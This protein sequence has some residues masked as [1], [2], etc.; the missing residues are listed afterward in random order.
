MI[1]KG[2]YVKVKVNYPKNKKLCGEFEG[3]V[4][5]VGCYRSGYA[6]FKLDSCPKLTFPNSSTYTKVLDVD[7]RQH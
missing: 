7:G 6:F 5:Q 3:K 2:E 1:R 4:T